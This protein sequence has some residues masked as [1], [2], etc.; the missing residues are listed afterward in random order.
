MELIVE[1][2][3]PLLRFTEGP[4]QFTVPVA[5]YTPVLPWRAIVSEAAHPRPAEPRTVQVASKDLSLWEAAGEDVE[6]W[7]AA[8][9]AAFIVTSGPDFIGVHMHESEAPDGNPLAGW[10]ASLRRQRF[11]YG[12]VIY[13]VGSEYA[14][15]WGMVWR[16]LSHP[17]PGH[18]P[19]AISADP[20]GSAPPLSVVL[21]V[22][23][24]LLPVSD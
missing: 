24:P 12:S 4:A 22:A 13:E 8:G 15:R 5:T 7:P 6:I 11:L 16:I 1:S 10:A 2:G 18:E 23:G 14:D 19:T 3:R 17:K 21:N 20:S 9:A